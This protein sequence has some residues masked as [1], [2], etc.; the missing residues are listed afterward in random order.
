[1]KLPPLE[2]LSI[3]QRVILTIVAV[4]VVVL[5]LAC[6]GYLSGRW[7]E[8]AA[9]ERPAYQLSKFEPRL[10]VLER[11]AVEDA[12]VKKITSLWT[13]WMSD[14]RGQPGRAIAGATQAR[15]AFIASMEEL[16]RRQEN[17]KREPVK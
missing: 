6:I 10:L 7:E 14:E 4:V 1:M 2:D 8:A 13:V 11:Q 12:F 9:Q 5:L 15:K 17:L 16:D 3:G